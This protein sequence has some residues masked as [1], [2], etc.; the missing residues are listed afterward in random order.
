MDFRL[1]KGE[2]THDPRTLMMTRFVLPEIRVPSKYDFDKGRKAIPIRLW[3]NNDWGDCVIAGQANHLLRLERV[4]QRRTISLV[5]QDVINRYKQMTGSMAPGDEKDQGLVVLHA[6]RHW[7]NNG[8]HLPVLTKSGGTRNYSI[9]AYGELDPGNKKQLRQAAYVFHGIHMGFWLPIAAQR[10]TSEGVWDYQGGTGPE[11]SPGSWGGH[12][13]YAKKFDEESFEVLTWGMKVKVTNEFINRYC[14]E[15]WAAV[16][17]FD[18][19][20]VKQTID[21]AKLRQQ[22][23]QISSKVDQ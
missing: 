8:W 7:R 11:W 1:G 14:D 16:D 21:V 5:D 13:V 15:A 23:Q 10:M 2:Y 19:W 4:E 9:S 6:M 12:L 22:L 18:S 20:R 3:G 17:N